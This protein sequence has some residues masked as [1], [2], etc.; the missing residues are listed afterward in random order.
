LLK[1]NGKPK[2]VVQFFWGF[3][4]CSLRGG[5]CGVGRAGAIDNFIKCG[6]FVF[7]P[8]V[9]TFGNPLVEAKYNMILIRSQ[10]YEPGTNDVAT[11]ILTLSPN[12]LGGVATK[13][14]ILSNYLRRA[15]K[16]VNNRLLSRK[17]DIP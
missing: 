2:V 7:P 5:V 16:D 15:G 1:W 6:L 11:L 14:K 9:E 17:W 12:I 8:T 3:N 10:I 4:G 13:A